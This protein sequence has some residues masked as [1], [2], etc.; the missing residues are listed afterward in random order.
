MYK[1][2]IV[3][4]EKKAAFVLK[5]MLESV[6]KD[7]QVVE[8]VNDSRNAKEVIEASPPDILFLDVDMPFL[9]GFEV[10]QSLADP[11]F[12]IIFVTGHD[13]YALNAFKCSASGYILKP[14]DVDDLDKTIKQA[15]LR[16]GLMKSA[17]MNKIL[18][19]NLSSNQEKKV[20]IPTMDGL[21]FVSM[22]DIIRCEGVLKCTK[23][24]VDNN[25]TIV[26]SYN[27][28]EFVKLLTIYGFFSTHKSHLINLNRINKYYKDGSIT[29]SDGST[30]PLARRRKQDFLNKIAKLH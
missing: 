2:I 15:V 21:D 5:T 13:E 10:L 16:L 26:S 20:G 8:I 23:V 25:K 30:I 22:S 6:A 29:M 4:D 7:I 1:A 9:N 17:E 11:N 14:I 24:Y 19:Q 28:G 27:L 12:E 18:I 3:D